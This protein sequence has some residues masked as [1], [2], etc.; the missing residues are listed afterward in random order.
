MRLRTVLFLAVALLTSAAQAGADPKG[1]KALYINAYH[2]GYAWSDGIQ[3]AL[4]ERLQ[5]AGVKVTTLL[6]DSKLH[7][8]QM[9]A[10]AK[11]AKALLD[12]EKPD[13]VIVSDDNPVKQFVTPYLK[14]ATTPVV[15]CGV[16][17]DGAAHGLPYANTTGMYEVAL[18]N[19]MVFAL[20]RYA[21][22]KRVGLVAGD[23]ETSRGDGA[24]IRKYGNQPALVDSYAKDVAGWKTAFLEM[25]GKADIVLL[26]NDGVKG[27]NDAEMGKWME[28]NTHVPTG[29]IQEEV[30]PFAMATFAKLPSEQ[31][32][33]AA[34][35]ALTILRGTK[36]ADIPTARNKKS[37]VILNQRI[38]KKLGVTFAAEDQRDA[39][40][41]N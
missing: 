9:E 11:E 24:G 17:W 29:A 6:M 23:N 35:A 30:A 15:F 41:L 7:P 20:S 14:D 25:Q 2:A 38:A 21:K 8:E 3:S 36:P 12:S 10:K 19:P 1:K 22:G 5:A 26:R 37:K 34:D 39:Q 27:W 33:W 28:E 18:V 16:N 13:I 4:L 31:G 32:Q 40:L